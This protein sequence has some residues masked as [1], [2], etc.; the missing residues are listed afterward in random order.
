[1]THGAVHQQ[2]EECGVDSERAP[3]PT[4]QRDEFYPA[5]KFPTRISPFRAGFFSSLLSADT[6]LS[7]LRLTEPPAERDSSH[8]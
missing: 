5:R 6:Q 8:K 1:M 4:I 2:R 3:P 7:E